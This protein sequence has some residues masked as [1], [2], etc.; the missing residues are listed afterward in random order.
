MCFED[1]EYPW[2]DRIALGHALDVY[3]G[4]ATD[5]PPLVLPTYQDRKAVIG[6]Q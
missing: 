2:D 3:L 6:G 5:P 1:V 4:R